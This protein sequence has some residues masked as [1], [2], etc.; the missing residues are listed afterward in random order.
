MDI[1]V[2]KSKR[3][4]AFTN[5]DVLSDFDAV[6]ISELLRNKEIS[7]SEVVQASVDRAKKVNPQLNAIVSECFENALIQP[8]FSIN[9]TFSGIPFFFKDN[10]DY[11]G[12]PSLHGSKAIKNNDINKNP[13][14]SQQLLD[15]GFIVLGK[16]A[17]PEFGLNASTE[18]KDGSATI[19]PWHSDY[20]CGASSGGSAA[21]VAAGVVPIAHANDGGGSIRIPAACCGLV[22]LKPSRGR[23]LDSD[24]SKVLPINIISEGVVTRSVRDTAYFFAEMEKSFS[25]PKLAKIGLI[26]H[27]SKRKLRIGLV[28]Q[29]ITGTV[30]QETTETLYQTAQLLEGLGHHITEYKLPISTRFVDDFSHYWGMLAFMLQHLGKQAFGQGF[31]A[32][33][34]DHLTLGLSNLY[35]NNFYKTPAFLYRLKKVQTDYM[36]IFNHYDV[37]LSPVVAHTTPKLGYLS[38]QLP[39]D[40]LFERIQNFV[41]FTPIQNIAGAPAMSIP[42]GIT[43]IDGLPI[44]M[45]ISANVGDEKTLIELAYAIEEVQPWRKIYD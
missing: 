38:P 15:Q 26:K 35:K 27:T 36:N 45:Q 28:T 10:I 29:S 25:N 6:K 23:T 24:A 3:I 31:D 11:A 12:L 9:R 37:L 39:F 32:K 4:H 40:E 33:E 17:L 22:G 18:F 30:D 20:S 21:L 43:Q 16:S 2:Q 7:V 8:K 44:S 34:L 19:N 1:D 13:K 5:D 41:T 42:M 14:L